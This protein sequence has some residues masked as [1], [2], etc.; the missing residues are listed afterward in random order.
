MATRTDFAARMIKGGKATSIA[1]NITIFCFPSVCQLLYLRRLSFLRLSRRSF[2]FLGFWFGQFT[3]GCL[4]ERGKVLAVVDLGDVEIIF[5]SVVRRSQVLLTE[6]SASCFRR[7]YVEA[8]VADKSEYL[9]VAINAVVAKHL[10]GGY[11]TRI[12]TLVYDVLY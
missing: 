9:A 10:P 5:R 2:S 1:R 7:L 4:Y 11:L 6:Q 12:G 3:A 8:V